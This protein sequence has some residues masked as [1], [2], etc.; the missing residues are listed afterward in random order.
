MCGCNGLLLSHAVC[1]WFTLYYAKYLRHI[2]N[3]C[4]AASIDTLKIWND[5]ILLSLARHPYTGYNVA[6]ESRQ[7]SVGTVQPSLGLD[8]GHIDI[9]YQL[10]YHG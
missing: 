7:T 1:L 5:T 8:V 3:N 2:C 6:T 9:Y 10:E 4:I